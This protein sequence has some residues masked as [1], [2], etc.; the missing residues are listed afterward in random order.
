MEE[1]QEGGREGAKQ[2]GREGGREGGRIGCRC[3]HGSSLSFRLL[4]SFLP[5]LPPSLPHSLP[6]YHE[7]VVGSPLVLQRVY[8]VGFVPAL[9]RVGEGLGRHIFAVVVHPARVT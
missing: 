8:I 4:P 7:E 9:M 5:S 2:G 3:T 1:K 6:P